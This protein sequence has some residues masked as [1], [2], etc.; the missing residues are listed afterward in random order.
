MGFKLLANTGTM[1]MSVPDKLQKMSVWN[2]IPT[3]WNS[4][5]LLLQKTKFTFLKLM[6]ELF[7]GFPKYVNIYVWERKYF[8]II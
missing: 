8:K 2:N 3:Q 5:Y 1:E 4:H 7:Q 6:G